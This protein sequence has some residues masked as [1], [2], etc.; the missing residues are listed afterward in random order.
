MQAWFKDLDQ[1]VLRSVMAVAV[2]LIFFLETIWLFITPSFSVLVV[3]V[4]LHTVLCVL[5]VVVVLSYWSIASTIPIMSA[6][7]VIFSFLCCVLLL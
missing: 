2:D 5:N 3:F 4:L 1:L 7:R 6:V